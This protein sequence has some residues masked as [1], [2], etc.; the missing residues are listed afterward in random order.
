MLPE[1]VSIIKPLCKAD[2][3][4]VAALRKRVATN[5]A[6]QYLL[7]RVAAQWRACVVNCPWPFFIGRFEARKS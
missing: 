5:A 1:K 2:S 4:I 7:I 6:T 3:C